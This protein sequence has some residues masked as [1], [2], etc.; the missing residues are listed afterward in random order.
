V[1][2]PAPIPPH[3]PLES[4]WLAGPRRHLPGALLFILLFAATFARYPVRIGPQTPFPSS[5]ESIRVALHLHNEGRFSSP[6]QTLETGPTAHLAPAFPLYLSLLMDRFGAGWQALSAIH[7]S[8]VFAAALT[9]ALLPFVSRLIGFGLI[10]GLIASALW[11]FATPYLTPTWEAVYASLGTLAATAIAWRYAARPSL[12]AA[13]ALGLASGALLLIAPS[14]LPVLAAW[15]AWLAYRRTP[16]LAIVLAVALAVTAPWM[17]RNYAVFG[18]FIPFRTNFGLEF[19][20]SNNDCAAHS[21]QL[22]IAIGCSDRLHPSASL[23]EALEVRDLGEPAYNRLQLEQGLQWVGGHPAAFV[24]LTARR[25][26]AFW[27]PH[28]TRDVLAELAAPGR[29]AQTWTIFAVTLLGFAGLR[30]GFALS[31]PAGLLAASWLALFPVVYYFV[32]H[33]DRYRLP[34]L[35]VSFLLAGVALH[36]IASWAWRRLRPSL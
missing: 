16:R 10:P 29:R 5:N 26:L 6:F 24:G 8:A 7:Y 9:V 36:A 17:I 3:R 19:A 15:L 32:Q 13:F 28:D 25:A 23:S 22:N 20:V 4:P 30:I 11:L 14:F 21:L 27:F 1:V 35:W 2:E 31:R 33:T 12:P 34:I 18:G